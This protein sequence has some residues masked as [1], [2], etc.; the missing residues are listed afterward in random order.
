LRIYTTGNYNNPLIW[1]KIHQYDY[2]YLAKM[3]IKLL[4]I[5]ATS[6]LSEGVFTTAG[7]PIAK[8]RT[9]LD[10]NWTNELVSPLERPPELEKFLKVANNNDCD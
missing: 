7:L 4:F 9:Q 3:A 1:W 5:P 8:D 10:S 2:P 6:A